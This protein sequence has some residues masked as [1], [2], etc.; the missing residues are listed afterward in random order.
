MP[1]AA[2]PAAARARR[3]PSRTLGRMGSIRLIRAHDG[4]GRGGAPDGG[5]RW[6]AFRRRRDE[7]LAARRALQQDHQQPLA[8]HLRV[9]GAAVARDP[10]SRAAVG[11]HLQNTGARI[12]AGQHADNRAALRRGVRLAAQPASRRRPGRPRRS[13]LRDRGCPA[14]HR[15]GRGGGAVQPLAAR[16]RILPPRR[17]A[18]PTEGRRAPARL[19]AAPRGLTVVATRRRRPLTP[20]GAA[21]DH[22]GAIQPAAGWPAAVACARRTW[23][24]LSLVRIS[25]TVASRPSRAIPA[26]ARKASWNPRVSVAG[27]CA[28]PITEVE[29]ADSTA[30]PSA[31]PTCWVV[32]IMPLASPCSRSGTPEIAAIVSG[33][34]A[35]PRPTAASREGPRMSATKLPWT[36]IC[37]NQ[38]SPAAISAMPV[39]RIGLKPTFVTSADATPAE[40]TIDSASGR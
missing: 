26:P 8:G 16:S 19:R 15:Y 3:H 4:P 20:G 30:R 2:E 28:V 12:Q 24:S 34:K 10:P 7:A 6:L 9:A 14:S 13:H 21:E 17:Q 40:T 5:R 33:T 25:V 38:I 23:A 22:R 36:E 35:R 37:E 11:A 29:I 1:Q 27:S 39:A 31:P 18:G 32:L